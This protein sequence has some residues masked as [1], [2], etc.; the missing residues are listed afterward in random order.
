M[1]HQA[2]TDHELARTGEKQST[3]GWRILL[4]GG[5]L[6]A[7]G[8]ICTFLGDDTIDFI[9][10]ALMSLATP[11]TVGGIALILSALVSKRSAQ[12]KPFA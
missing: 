9:G 4:V 1:P 10:V 12:H 2:M 11:F 6:F 3:T 7:L 5:V 8:L